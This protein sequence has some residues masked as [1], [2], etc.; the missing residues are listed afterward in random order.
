[1]AMHPSFLRCRPRL[2]MIGSHPAAVITDRNPS[3]RLPLC[4]GRVH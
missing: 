3:L 2:P 4:S 1:M